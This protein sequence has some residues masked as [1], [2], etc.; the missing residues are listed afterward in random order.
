MCFKQ[1][2]RASRETSAFAYQ[3]VSLQNGAEIFNTDLTLRSKLDVPE[4]W[5]RRDTDHTAWLCKETLEAGHSA[6]VFCGTKKVEGYKIRLACNSDAL[7]KM[8]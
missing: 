4:G 6:L 2:V 5:N 3:P 1:H 7:Y 8:A